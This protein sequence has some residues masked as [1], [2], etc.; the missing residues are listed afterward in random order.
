MPSRAEGFHIE[1]ISAES[2]GA[3]ACETRAPRPPRALRGSARVHSL[4]CFSVDEYI[5]IAKEKHGYNMEQ[6]TMFLWL[7]ETGIRCGVGGAA[8][9][10]W[11]QLRPW[12]LAPRTARSLRVRSLGVGG[13]GGGGRSGLSHGAAGSAPEKCGWRPRCRVLGT[14]FLT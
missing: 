9:S 5:A 13:G 6:V 11:S 10:G 1:Y 7:L 8:M 2:C 4:S 3:P 14:C 12:A